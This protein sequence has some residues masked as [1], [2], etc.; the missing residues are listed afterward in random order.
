MKL[1]RAAEYAIRGTLGLALHA[2]SRTPV[3]VSQIAEEQEVSPAFLA[4][5]FQQLVKAGIV[6]SHRGVKGGFTLAQDPYRITIRDVMEAVEGP[7]ALNQCLVHVNPCKRANGCPVAEI[8]R[9]AQE[10]MLA[11][12]DSSSIGELVSHLQEAGEVPAGP[13]AGSS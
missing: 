9:K 1:T 13:S 3:L 7:T 10:S 6:K 5:I 11:V 8:W 12:L 2:K 4:K